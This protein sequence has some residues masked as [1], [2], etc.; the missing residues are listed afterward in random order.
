ME[1]LTHMPLSYNPGMAPLGK[2]LFNPSNPT[3]S[4]TFLNLVALGTPTGLSSNRCTTQV[5]ISLSILENSSGCRLASM[6]PEAVRNATRTGAV[7]SGRGD[8][9]MGGSR[10]RNRRSQVTAPACPPSNVCSAGKEDS[11]LASIDM[12]PSVLCINLSYVSK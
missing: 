10:S 11:M 5:F 7:R 9:G 6:C 2:S 4:N 1:F 12:S 3:L 8:A